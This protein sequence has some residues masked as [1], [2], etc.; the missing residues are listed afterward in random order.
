[1][2][3]D[4]HPAA[5]SF[6]GLR[7]RLVQGLR[8]V[9]EHDAATVVARAVVPL[10]DVEMQLYFTASNGS[11][12][13]WRLLLIGD[14]EAEIHIEAEHL[15][16]RA[17]GKERNHA[18]GCHSISRRSPNTFHRSCRRRSDNTTPA[19]RAQPERRA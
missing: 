5:G 9:Y 8:I 15:P 3:G 10:H 2:T 18:L 1:N 7:E 12:D 14:G 19:A 16:D 6:E 13:V 17:A 11:V 4:R